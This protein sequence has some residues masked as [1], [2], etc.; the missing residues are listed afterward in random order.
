[1]KA[2]TKDFAKYEQHLSD[3]A[4]KQFTSENLPSGKDGFYITD[5]DGVIRDKKGNLMLIEKKCRNQKSSTCQN[6]TLQVLNY[7]LELGYRAC[8]GKVPIS[9]DGQAKIIPIHYHG[10]HLLQLS[11]NDFEDSIFKFDG[12]LVSR[13]E[14]I[15]I[16]SFKSFNYPNYVKSK[17]VKMADYRG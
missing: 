7:L 6:I 9:I 11:H 8:S 15:D 17:V 1:M 5:I 14:L 4:F 12:R 10:T 2:K 16:M 3:L 13:S